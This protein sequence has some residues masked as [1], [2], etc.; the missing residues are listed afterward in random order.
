MNIAF[1][2]LGTEGSPNFGGMEESTFRIAQYFVSFGAKVFLYA[3]NPVLSVDERLAYEHAS[4][5]FVE[6]HQDVTKVGEPLPFGGDVS[7]Q[8]RILTL[9]FINHLERNVTANP[10]MNHVIVSFLISTNGFI[11]QNAAVQ[12][13]FPH[14]ACIRGTDFSRDFFSY[15]RLSA[16][17]FVIQNARWIITTNSQQLRTINAVF[18]RT[19]RVTTIFNPISVSLDQIWQPKR[20][21]RVRFFCD[22]GYSFK[23]GTH[24]IV[25]A[26]EELVS[27][28]IPLSL[29]IVGRQQKEEKPYWQKFI[30]ERL[31]SPHIH[32]REYVSKE[33]LYDLLLDADIYCSGSL[34][35][36]CA[37]G[38]LNA[39]ALGL[40]IVATDCGALRE[41]TEGFPHVVL[42][43][44]GDSPALKGALAAAA[45]CS[46]EGGLCP[47][48]QRLA[49]MHKNFSADVERTCW[50]KIAEDIASNSKSK[51]VFG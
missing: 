8:F 47:D 37:N 5:H 15:P 10:T 22:T 3:R 46:L 20:R 36:G 11:A 24:I 28:G 43:P 4:I 6:L 48:M 49:Q 19:A 41:I 31:S 50:Q 1:H 40:P 34:G 21:D 38:S 39:A 42:V 45:N 25:T 13:G 18:Q 17:D 2:I 14:I 27:E 29:T 23:K 12:L 35:E 44:P 30:R 32:L 26:V 7:E 33:Q 51:Q 9:V 16:I